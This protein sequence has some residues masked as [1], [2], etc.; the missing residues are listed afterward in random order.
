MTA[1]DWDLFED[2]CAATGQVAL[3]TT[4]AAVQAFVDEVQAAPAVLVRRLGAIRARHEHARQDLRGAPPRQPA[5]IPWRT[6]GELVDPAQPG[7]P[8]WLP[9]PEA[10]HLLPVYGWPHAL[11]ARRDALI[12]TVAARGWSRRQITELGPEQLRLEP[13][14]AIDGVDVPMTNHGLTCPSCALTRWLRVLAACYAYVDGAWE[15]VATVVEDQPGD[16][17]RHDCGLPHPRGWERAPWVLPS[18]DG[19]GRIQLGSQLPARRVSAVL[20]DR[21]Q[22]PEATATAEPAIRATPP[23]QPP[24]LAERAATAHAIDDILDDLD[25]AIDQAIAHSN[26]LLTGPSSTG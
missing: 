14:P 19:H 20:A 1:E 21:Q 15:P 24:S 6:P 17:H 8:R 13:V 11:S 18:I 16:V 26:T 3:P 25:V 10:L 23:R 2:W 12:L 5:P 22:P 9:L 7:G 4:W